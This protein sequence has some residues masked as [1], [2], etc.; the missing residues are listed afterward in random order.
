LDLVEQP[1]VLDG[2]RALSRES[3]DEL[4]LTRV[5]RPDR[6]PR[7]NGTPRPVRAPMLSIAFESSTLSSA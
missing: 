3:L 7:S 1:H 2:D 6:D 5:K 4:D